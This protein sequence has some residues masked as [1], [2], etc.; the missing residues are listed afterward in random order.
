MGLSSSI[1]NIHFKNKTI[2]LV[3]KL[4]WNAKIVA[5][6]NWNQTLAVL[7]MLAD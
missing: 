6:I 5:E 7:E 1:K 3:F 2:K 4:F